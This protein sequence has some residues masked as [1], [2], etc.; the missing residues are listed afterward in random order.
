[1]EKAV[2]LALRLVDDFTNESA[3]RLPAAALRR[4]ADAQANASGGSVRLASLFFASY[5]VVEP[6]WDFDSV[7]TGIRGARG[8]KLLGASMT[9]RHITLHLNVT[10]FGENLGWKGNVKNVKLSNDPKFKNFLLALH[11]AS[12]E[13]RHEVLEYI[14]A[15]FANSQK[16]P[17]ALPPVGPEVLTFARAKLLFHQ[18][19]EVP[20]EGHIQQFLIAALLAVHRQRSGNEVTTHHPHAADKYDGTAG[21]VE[22]FSNGTLVGAYEVTVRADWQNRLPDF[23]QKIDNFGLKKYVIIASKVNDSPLLANP[24]SLLGLIG[25]QERDIAVIDIQDFVNVFAAELSAVELRAAVD[26]CYGYLLNPKLCGRNDFQESFA[27]VVAHW[28][29]TA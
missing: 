26:R 3:T 8:D 29:D 7:P 2:L 4:A 23:R 21:D 22:E 17:A 15:L 16:I 13:E 5:A 10:A 18:L 28:L 12:S 1:M 19:L 6:S 24:K 14:A 20:S 27:S 11:L 25:R 9:D